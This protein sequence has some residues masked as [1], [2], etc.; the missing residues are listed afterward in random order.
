MP[1]V[2]SPLH[3]EDVP[4]PPRKGK[5]GKVQ[6]CHLQAEPLQQSWVFLY[7]LQSQAA[8]P[9][10]TSALFLPGSCTGC[11]ATFSVLKK[12]VSLRLL[13]QLAAYTWGRGVVCVWLVLVF[14][15]SSGGWPQSQ[16]GSR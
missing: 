2:T 3:G 4:S 11:A 6:Q 15:S 14:S 12:R 7:V 13:P 5:D 10:L 1:P 9:C 8:E 16:H